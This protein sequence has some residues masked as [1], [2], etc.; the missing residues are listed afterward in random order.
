MSVSWWFEIVLIGST[1]MG[2]VCVVLA[3]IY[4]LRRTLWRSTQ[5]VR[6]RPRSHVTVLVAMRRSSDDINA[7][8]K[9]IRRLHYRR[10]DIVVFADSRVSREAKSAAR[11]TKPYARSYIARK[12]VGREALVRNAYRRSQRGE[13]VLVLDASSVLYLRSLK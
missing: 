5:A 2:M 11:A 3:S 8:V 6:S 1:A 9:S 12:P 10:Y 7:C 13:M 4:D